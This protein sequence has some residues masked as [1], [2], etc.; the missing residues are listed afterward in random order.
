MATFYDKDGNEVTAYSS[1]ELKN[2]PEFKKLEEE[3]AAAKKASEDGNP[4]QKQ[5]LKE[6]AQE[7]EKNLETFK[8]EMEEKLNKIQSNMTES[9]KGKFLAQFSKGNKEVSDKIDLK[10]QN[11]MKTGEYQNTE[12]GISQAMADAATLVN[13]SRPSPSIM[14]NMAGAGSRGNG[15][16]EAAK[17]VETENEVAMRAPLGITAED[18]KKYGDKVK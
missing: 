13:G 10:F 17:K 16:G 12:E 5:R 18:I 1:E 6:Q 8:K 4:G 15:G 3:L 9:V 7:A 11:L 2:L 14:D